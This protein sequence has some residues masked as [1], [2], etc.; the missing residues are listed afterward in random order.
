VT[1]AQLKE[2]QEAINGLSVKDSWLQKLKEPHI[3]DLYNMLHGGS[4]MWEIV[5]KAYKEWLPGLG[6]DKHKMMGELAK[7]R[8]KIIPDGALV[9][10]QAERGDAEAQEIASRLESFKSRIDGLGRLSWLID[11]QSLRLESLIQREEK[12]LPLTLTNEVVKTLGSLLTK[13]IQFQQD[14]GEVTRMP[15]QHLVGV[16]AQFEKLDGSAVAQA[17]MKMLESIEQQAI[18]I[19]ANPVMIEGLQLPEVEE[20][21]ELLV[22][23][24]S[25]SKRG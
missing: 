13:Y 25:Q 2:M 18:T 1:K 9:R 8:V 4:T 22:V 16:R 15:T 14:I 19:D 5:D 7:F 6:H 23:G 11:K 3:V 20:E 17:T 12:G 10:V 21:P 24:T